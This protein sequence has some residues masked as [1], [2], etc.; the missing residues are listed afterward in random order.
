EHTYE[1]FAGGHDWPYWR[2]HLADSLR[3]LDGATTRPAG[4]SQGTPSRARDQRRAGRSV[5]DVGPA[6][7]GLQ[8]GPARARAA[9]VQGHGAAGVE[10]QDAVALVLR[11]MMRVARDDDAEPGDRGIEI[12]LVDVVED[13]DAQAGRLEHRRLGDPPRPGALVVVA[14]HGGDGRDLLQRR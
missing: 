8:S 11:R 14:A 3:F 4:G 2:L 13:V 5:A 10:E 6:G 7:R 1:E 9:L 12:E